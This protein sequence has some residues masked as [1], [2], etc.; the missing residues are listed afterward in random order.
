MPAKLQIVA[1]PPRKPGSLV[2]KP[3]R[4]LGVHGTELWKSIMSEYAIDDCAGI[5]ILTAACQQIDRA[6]ALRA[7]IDRDGA[8]VL[9][10]H[11]PKE[12]PALK[13]ELAARAFILRC[14]QRL[15]LDAEAVKPIGHTIG[16]AA[17][18]EVQLEHLLFAGTT[19]A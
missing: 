10:K 7:A 16:Q 17:D 3:S 8:I 11:G 2:V 12:H 18:T 15:G 4:K 19:S 9:G 1:N 13:P 6:E 14:F 5:E